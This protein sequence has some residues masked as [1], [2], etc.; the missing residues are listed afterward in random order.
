ME[1]FQIT[2]PPAHK[3]QVPSSPVFQML[4][5]KEYQCRPL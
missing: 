1:K 2:E 5:E 4:I 3:V